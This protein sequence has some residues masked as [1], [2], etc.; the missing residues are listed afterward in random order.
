MRR[1]DRALLPPGVITHLVADEVVTTYRRLQGLE[2]LLEQRLFPL[3][4]A[5]QHVVHLVP[6]DRH[7]AL[8]VA[9]VIGMDLRTLLDGE[10]DA[11]RRWQAREFLTG[12]GRERVRRQHHALLAVDAMRRV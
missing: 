1:G 4:C 8:D 12:L 11:L 7:A 2:P 6:G 10:L 3:R 5:T 9:A